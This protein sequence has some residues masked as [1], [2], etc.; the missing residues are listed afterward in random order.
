MRGVFGPEDAGSRPASFSVAEPRFVSMKSITSQ[1]E[2]ALLAPTRLILASHGADFSP[3]N[4]LEVVRRYTDTMV[5]RGRDTCGPQ[6]S[7]LL[8]SAP[9]RTRPAP[10]D[11][12]PT[13]PGSIRRGDRPGRPRRPG[14][15]SR[16]EVTA[17]L[18]EERYCCFENRSSPALQAALANATKV[19]P[20]VSI[21][22]VAA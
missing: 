21:H 3:T 13:P 11:L 17:E 9:D 18:W 7:E 4:F 8:L 14:G 20:D 6:K 15:R 5:E 19:P 1:H 12:R 2:S 10:L 22:K 16:T